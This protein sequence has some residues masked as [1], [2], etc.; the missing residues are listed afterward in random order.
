MS[1]FKVEDL[2]S[3]DVLLKKTYSSDRRIE[4]T[5]FTNIVDYALYL[6]NKETHRGYHLRYNSGDDMMFLYENFIL[7]K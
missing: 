7:E 5:V 2:K 6:C 3:G 1:E 4:Y